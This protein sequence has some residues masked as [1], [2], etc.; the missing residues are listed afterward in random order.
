MTDLSVRIRALPSEAVERRNALADEVRAQEDELKKL[1][2]FV[3]RFSE[4]S[5]SA[6][7]NRLA[8]EAHIL[9]TGQWRER[10]LGRD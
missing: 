4:W 10:T 6:D 1:R 7:L 5:N 3:Q 8:G 2:G 9:I